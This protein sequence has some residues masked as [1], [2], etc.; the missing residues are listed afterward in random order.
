MQNGSSRKLCPSCNTSIGVA[1]KKCKFCGATIQLKV[2]LEAQKRKA[3]DEWANKTM[4]HGRY[5]TLVNAAN[6][7]VHGFHKVG[8]HPLLLLC[9]RKKDNI[10]PSTAL[11][12][13]SGMV[14]QTSMAAIQRLYEA[15]VKV[16]INTHTPTIQP[17]NP[18]PVAAQELSDTVSPQ[19]TSYTLILNQV[20][21]PISPTAQETSYT[22]IL[23][24]VE[25]P[26]SPTAQETSYTLILNQVEPP[27]SPTAQETSYTL[28][29]NQVEPP[30]SL[31]AQETSYTLILNQVEPPISPTAQETSYTLILNQVESPIS[32]TAQETSYT[33]ILNQVESPISPTAQET[34]YTLILNQ[35]ESPISPT[36]QETSYTLILNQVEPPISPTAQETSYT[37]IL[38]QVEPPISP[39]AQETS[40]TLILNQVE[41]PISPTTQDASYTLILNQVEPP[42][43][44]TAQETSYTHTKPK[45]TERKSCHPQKTLQLAEHDTVNPIQPRPRKRKYDYMQKVARNGT[46]TGSRPRTAFLHLLGIGGNLPA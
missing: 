3:T 11:C 22:L 4:K 34:S 13:H 42:I 15:I 9:K 24:Q 20:E 6:K 41:P 37:L 14:N 28:I 32:P 8:V 35:V 1:S 19:E 12:P 26:I 33:L 23:N 38:N 45:K 30:I 17:S 31:T 21:P 10:L 44:P 43:S 39:T 7:L 27:I 5:A 40:Y 18:P 25:P 36:A 2:K 46:M 29:L 16:A